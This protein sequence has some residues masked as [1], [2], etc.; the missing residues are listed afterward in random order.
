MPEGAQ[1]LRPFALGDDV[2]GEPL[3]V[4]V[5][6]DEVVD[7][8]H[9]ARSEL[10]PDLGVAAAAGHD[11]APCLGGQG[12]VVGRG[13]VP[14]AA[15]GYVVDAGVDVG[16]SL[17]GSVEAGRILGVARVPG[18]AVA[19]G[20]IDIAVG[21]FLQQTPHAAIRPEGHGALFPG[22]VEQDRMTV[23]REM[24]PVMSSLV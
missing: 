14:A 9:F 7:L 3:D 1:E 21:V 13:A 4:E 8:P 20:G 11:L 18:D 10:A 12:V 16:G 19:D 5:E 15:H 2:F 17:E 24:Y 23:F 22:G 6:R